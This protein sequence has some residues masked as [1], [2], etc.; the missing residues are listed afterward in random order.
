MDL[1]F[2]Q[3]EQQVITILKLNNQVKDMYRKQ[4]ELN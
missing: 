1:K 2:R 4:K 3:L